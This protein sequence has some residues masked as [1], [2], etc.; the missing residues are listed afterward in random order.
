M[1]IH[2]T[3]WYRGE[4][5]PWFMDFFIRKCDIMNW[6]DIYQRN[7]ILDSHFEQK[8]LDT[9]PN[10]FEKNCLELTIEIAE[11]A[12][13]T[14]CFKY[15]TVKPMKKEET[16]EECADVIMMLLYAYNHLDV[17]KIDIRKINSNDILKDFNHIFYLSTT[18]MENCKKEIVDEIFGYTLGIAESLG[19]TE[20]MLTE[21]CNKKIE[22]VEQ[23]LKEEY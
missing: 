7:K 20:N 5:R 9:E 6:N 17:S 19:L 12:N 10:Y 15:W 13:E 16:L 11:F 18:L 21:A 3:R 2:K 1:N 22:K 4:T 14:K 8:Y 23:R